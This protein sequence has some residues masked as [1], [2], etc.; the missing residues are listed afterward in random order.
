MELDN[1]AEFLEFASRAIP[2][3]F[4]LG[5]LT[6]NAPAA[7]GGYDLIFNQVTSGLNTNSVRAVP[8]AFNNLTI[9][10]AAAAPQLIGVDFGGGTVPGNWNSFAGTA[11]GTLTDLIDESG[12]TTVVDLNVTVDGNATGRGTEAFAPPVGQLPIHPNTLTGLDGN[13]YDVGN[14]QVTFS[15]LVVGQFYEVYVFGGDT[16]TATQTVQITGLTNPITYTH[17]SNQLSRRLYVFAHNNLR[18]ILT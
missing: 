17:G 3:V 11:S 10:V 15:A 7:A 16:T 14:I 13:Y 8:D 9:N 4:L 12:T 6:V 1:T 18:I 5:T 2:N